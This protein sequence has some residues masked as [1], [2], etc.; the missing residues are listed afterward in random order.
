MI[1]S[2]K[3]CE[4]IVNCFLVSVQSYKFQANPL[5]GETS[6]RSRRE[7]ADEPRTLFINPQHHQR[8]PTTIVCITQ[9]KSVSAFSTTTTPVTCRPISNTALITTATA[10]CHRTQSLTG[11]G[12]ATWSHRS[13]T[14]SITSTLHAMT[15]VVLWHRAPNRN[16]I[17]TTTDRNRLE[18][19]RRTDRAAAAAVR[20]LLLISCSF[21][22]CLFVLY[23]FN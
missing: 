7:K 8:E 23:T 20:L 6:S 12:Y 10:T 2:L 3:S 18:I 13:T 9:T 16:C 5:S 14:S 21:C 1:E 19:S 22:F 15:S 17:T 11:T 4:F